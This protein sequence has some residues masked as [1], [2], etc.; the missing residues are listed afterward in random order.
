MESIVTHPP[1]TPKTHTHLNIK[2]KQ[3]IIEEYVKKKHLNI[4]KSLYR[5]LF[6]LWNLPEK[7]RITLFYCSILY[8][9][10]AK[11]RVILND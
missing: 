6:R 4:H 5:T 11:M 1:K 10:L 7:L 9:I 2:K 3:K 8:F